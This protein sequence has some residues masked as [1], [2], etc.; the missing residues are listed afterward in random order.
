[1]LIVSKKVLYIGSLFF[2]LLHGSGND[3]KNI[4]WWNQNKYYNDRKVATS[5]NEFLSGLLHSI[6]DQ[7][8]PRNFSTLNKEYHSNFFECLEQAFDQYPIS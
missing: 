3:N 5:D 2:I 1:M 4:A 8:S 6:F 7:R